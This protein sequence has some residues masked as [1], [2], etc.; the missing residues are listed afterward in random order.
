[1]T[2]ALTLAVAGWLLVTYHG[3]NI[4]WYETDVSCRVAAQYISNTTADCIP[5]RFAVE[6]LRQSQETKP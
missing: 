2:R 4:A 3:G 6:E 5:D 1:M